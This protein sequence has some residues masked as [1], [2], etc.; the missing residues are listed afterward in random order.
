MPED[1][2]AVEAIEKLIGHPIPPFN[3]EGLDPV[4]WADDDGRRRRGRGRTARPR[5]AAREASAPREKAAREK[6]VREKPAPQPR[7]AKPKAVPRRTQ[8]PPRETPRREP[9]RRD[10]DLG[11]GVKGFGDDVPAFMLLRS[12]A[13]HVT[14]SPAIEEAES[15]A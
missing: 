11:P 7:A 6:P 12:R 8:P 14:T 4:D 13:A 1:R 3:V 2:A 10:D 15:E 9:R 5:T